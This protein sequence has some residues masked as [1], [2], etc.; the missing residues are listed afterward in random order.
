[1]KKYTL[2][3]LL[4]FG[5]L[6]AIAQ[7]EVELIIN[8]SFELGEQ[9]W[10]ISLADNAYAD[11][12]GCDANSGQSY[13]WFGDANETTGV[14][15]IDYQEVTQS[16]LLPANLDFAEFSFKW[17]G[18]SDE[19]DDETPWDYLYVDLYDENGVMIFDFEITNVDLNPS[20]TVD[21][22]DD[23]FGGLSFTIGS[24]YAGQNIEVVITVLTDDTFPTIFRIDD[25]SIMAVS[26]SVGL[27]ENAISIINVSP[28]P[29]N[30]KIVITNNS[31]SYVGIIIS[32][33]EGRTLLSENLCPGKNEINMSSLANGIYFIKESNGAVT[34]IVKQ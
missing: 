18:S 21:D 30:E 8:G 14:N 31:N 15:D 10:D 3:T 13:L 5:T 1:M 9:G 24:Q 2:F 23:W 7:Q 32:N 26:T 16:V 22:C 34:K 20:L 19:Q 17:S 28:N 12:G 6:S 27:L 29:A 33:A 11:E 4:L 25:V